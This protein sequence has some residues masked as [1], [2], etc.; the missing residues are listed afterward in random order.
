M[1]PHIFASESAQILLLL[2]RSDLNKA[3]TYTVSPGVESWSLM[4]KPR[5]PSS[6]GAGKVS[7]VFR[8]AVFCTPLHKGDVLQKLV[9]LYTKLYIL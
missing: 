4:W 6:N 7:M 5:V 2:F 3:C 9:L 1:C 8:W